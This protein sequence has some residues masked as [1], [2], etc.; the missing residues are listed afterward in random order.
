MKTTWQHRNGNLYTTQHD[1]FG[2][3]IAVAGP[4]DWDASANESQY[5]NKPELI[6]WIEH[7]VQHHAMHKLC[8]A[9]A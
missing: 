8:R 6:S 4:L 1:A 7:Q 2:H 9:V 3:I 5:T